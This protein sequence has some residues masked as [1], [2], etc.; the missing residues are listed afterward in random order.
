MSKFKL[1]LSLSLTVLLSNYGQKSQADDITIVTTI[2]PLQLIAQAIVDG[3]SSVTSLLPTNQSPHHYS[4]TPS[5]RLAIADADLLIWTG[6]ALESFLIATMENLGRSKKVITA[7]SLE[8]LVLYEMAENQI[9]PHFWLDPGNALIVAESIE[10]IVSAL[11]KT[12]AAQYTENLHRFSQAITA[13]DVAFEP[14]QEKIKSQPYAVYHS[15]YQYLENYYGLQHGLAL[16]ADPEVQP[17]IRAMMTTRATLKQ[18]QPVCLFTDVETNESVVNTLLAGQQ[19]K[20]TELDPIGDKV[21]VNR[22]A[23]VTMIS[24]L[25][26]QMSACLNPG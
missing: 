15:A 20:R 5:D 24:N 26:Q 2:K 7:L 21:S 6:P 12:N 19:I 17:G 10:K 16:V 9:D 11:D 4:L 18:L 23:Y 22:E 1:A 13:M 3:Q 8:N 25:L 14:V